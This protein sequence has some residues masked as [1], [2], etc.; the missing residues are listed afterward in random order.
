MFTETKIARI[1]EN[2]G[3]AVYSKILHEIGLYS[4][5]WRLSDLSF[6]EHYSMN[7]IFFCK[8]EQYGACV[9]KIG[10]GFQDAEYIS[11]Y[12]VL[13]EYGGRRFIKIFES[14]ISAGKRVMLLERIFPG[15]VLKLETSLPKR[16]AAFSG[17]FNGMHIKPE[18]AALYTRFTDKVSSF[19]AYA[20]TRE[21]CKDLHSHMARAKELCASI[22]VLYPEEMLL[23]GDMHFGNILKRVDG[24]Y[25]AIDPQGLVGPSVFDIPRY[26]LVEYYNSMELSVDDRF[27]KINRIIE[28]FEGSLSVPDEVIR[29]CFYVETVTFECWSASVG[30]YN[31][32]NV[33]FAETIMRQ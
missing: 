31:V 18:N 16:L 10:C 19:T 22:S 27:D 26:I 20:G 8:S 12:N 1:I 2:W 13:R 6:C 7:A 30:K 4:E 3:Q 25:A 15:T 28:Y 32:D 21:D 14:D 17:L 9:L 23:H 24:S 29:Q 33:M 11:E 5:K